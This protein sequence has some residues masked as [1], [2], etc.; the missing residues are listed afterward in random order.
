MRDSHLRNQTFS[1]GSTC[2]E[3]DG[4]AGYEVSGL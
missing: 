4:C 1:L 2:A 3:R